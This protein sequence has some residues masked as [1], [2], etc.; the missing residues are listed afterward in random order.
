ML[1]ILD[2][3]VVVKWFKKEADTE[4]ALKIREQFHRGEHEIIVPDLLLYEISNALRYDKKFSKEVIE[5][6][7]NTLIEMDIIITIPS[8]ELISEALKIALN[9]DMTVYDAVYISLANQ[10]N[11]TFVTADE[12]LFEKIKSLK[13]CRLLKD[14]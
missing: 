2:A 12:K 6:A 3:S 10:T 5:K 7:I 9:L 11:G 14:F 4:N 13:N 1:L 8:E